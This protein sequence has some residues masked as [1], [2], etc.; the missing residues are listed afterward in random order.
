MIAIWRDGWK[1][2]V[3]APAIAAGVFAMTIALALPMAVVLRGEIATHLHGS[4]RASSVADGV[5]WDWW[6]EFTG[7]ATGLGTT[8][9]PS[10]IGFATTLD[11]ISS[12]LDRK[13]IAGPIA[14]ALAFYL[15]GWAFLSGGII[16]R[17]A[18]QRPTRTYGFF[19]ASGVFFFRF[20]RLGVVSGIVYWWLFAYVH[21]WM[22][23]SAFVSLTR[24]L[25]VERTAF[26]W[27]VAFYAI[28]GALL[29][30]VNVLID[31]T[32]IRI[33][34]EDRRSALGAIGA[35]WRFV[36][37]HWTRV[38]GLYV[39]NS[40]AFLVLA[41]IWAIVAPGA[42]GGGLSIAVTFAFTQLYVIARL[43]MKL[44]FIASQTALFQSHLAHASYTAA[45]EPVWP[46][47]AVAESITNRD[48]SVRL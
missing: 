23:D 34:V 8:L 48:R 25:S 9:T 7:Q 19:A 4:L 45:P 16:D 5:D 37:Q 42:G 41:A 24:N 39:M 31:Y 27:R 3:A 22:F 1:R 6:Q 21:R 36:R 12:V 38:L 46:D 13:A 44:Q 43:L 14:M 35:A 18:R 32:R 28:F 29:I 10:V 47:S 30:G 11:S 33:V 40:I 2:V 20:V 15:A 26:L 17:Y